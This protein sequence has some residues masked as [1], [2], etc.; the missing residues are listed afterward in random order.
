MKIFIWMR[1]EELTEEYH[2][3]GGACVIAPDEETA[4]KTL[5]GNP[6]CKNPGKPDYSYEVE[7][8]EQKCFIFADSGCC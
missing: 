2:P 3:Q 5:E 6:G 1:V 8:K 4:I 7:A